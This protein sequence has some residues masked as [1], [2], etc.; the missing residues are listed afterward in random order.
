[1]SEYSNKSLEEKLEIKENTRIIIINFPLT[2]LATLK[3]P[4]STVIEDKLEGQFDLIQF[5]AHDKIEIERMFPKLKH[6]LKKDGTLWISW[7]KGSRMPGSLK[8]NKIRELGLQNG[9]VD[10]KVIL[11][12]DIWSGL[13][14]CYRITDR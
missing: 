3:I 11:I 9:L 6:S 8:E 10:T 1:M 14:F 2:Y 12:D 13:K 4:I 5:F 7:K